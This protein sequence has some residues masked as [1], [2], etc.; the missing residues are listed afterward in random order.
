MATGF[1]VPAV[2]GSFASNEYTKQVAY[3]L[4]LGFA[5]C[6]VSWITSLLL[7][8]ID[9]YAD[10]VEGK[11]AIVLSEEEK[12]HWSDLRKF[13]LPYWL[14]VVSCVMVYCVIFP[15]LSLVCHDMLILKYGYTPAEAGHTNFM[16]YLISAFLCAPFGI[17]IDKVGRRAL[18]S[19]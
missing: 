1:V 9:K 19:K 12:F 8:A 14:L 17:I 11:T 6:V 4:F 3:T 5:V 2:T 15:F 13:Q 10:K 18:F 16:P 7:A